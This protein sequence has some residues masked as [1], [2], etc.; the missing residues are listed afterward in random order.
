MAACAPAW[1]ALRLTALQFFTTAITGAI[2]LSD[3]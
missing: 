3:A 1:T 2:G